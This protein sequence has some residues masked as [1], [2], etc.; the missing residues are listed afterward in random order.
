LEAHSVAD[1][2]Q[3]LRPPVPR[4]L[5]RRNLFSSS[6]LV[7]ETALRLGLVAL[8]SFW[9]ARS[10]GPEQFGLLNF[11]SALV[12]ALTSLIALVFPSPLR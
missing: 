10:F 6:V 1:A 11:A 12:M 9:I 3:A 5:S 4:L 8:V 2:E 7:F